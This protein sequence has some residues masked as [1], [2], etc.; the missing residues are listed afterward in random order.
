MIYEITSG[1]ETMICWGDLCHHQVLL[2]EHPEWNFVFDHD[3]AEATS[4]RVRTYEFVDSERYAVFG[5]HFPF[6]GHGHLRRDRNGYTW[7]P[8]DL[9]RSLPGQIR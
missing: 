9:P 3:G 6:P 5:Y 8:S 7:I 4:Q 1:D 2:L